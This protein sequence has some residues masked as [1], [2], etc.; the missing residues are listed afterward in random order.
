MYIPDNDYSIAF[1]MHF[2]RRESW[3]ISGTR[4]RD[5]RYRR[6]DDDCM[7]S[8]T[9]Y[10][11]RPTFCE[12]LAR[13]FRARD[14]LSDDNIREKCT[15]V[16]IRSRNPLRRVLGL[17]TTWETY[18]RAILRFSKYRN[19]RGSGPITVIVRRGRYK[20]R[21]ISSDRNSELIVANLLKTHVQNYHQSWK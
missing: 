4:K 2:R 7:P 12:T 11:E 19:S 14:S 20:A 13:T 5:R 9:R 10:D 21:N 15:M 8:L 18:R 6:D 3:S 17:A 1:S 16:W